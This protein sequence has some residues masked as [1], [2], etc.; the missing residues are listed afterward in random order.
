MS[1][2]GTILC[3]HF[4]N[5]KYPYLNST[6]INYLNTINECTEIYYIIIKMIYKI[7]FLNYDPNIS[8]NNNKFTL[9]NDIVYF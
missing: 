9:L 8:N 2:F 1:L 6:S 3:K 7:I 5:I 4:P